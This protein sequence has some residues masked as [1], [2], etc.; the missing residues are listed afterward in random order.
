MEAIIGWGRFGGFGGTEQILFVSAGV[1]KEILKGFKRRQLR[2][3]LFRGFPA[4]GLGALK[5][6]ALGSKTVGK[7]GE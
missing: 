7:D 5:G 6:P 3:R 2:A 4:S 1:Q